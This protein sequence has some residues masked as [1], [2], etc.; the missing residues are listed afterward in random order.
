MKVN[1]VKR[2]EEAIDTVQI[3][4]RLTRKQLGELKKIGV[5]NG[6]T[7]QQIIY[8]MIDQMLADKSF[9]LNLT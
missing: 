1:K 9:V 8:S 5:E 7:A 3:S 4:L 6:V 2:T